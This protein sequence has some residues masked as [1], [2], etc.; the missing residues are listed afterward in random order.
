M[1]PTEWRVGLRAGA[2][3]CAST[4]KAARRESPRRRTSAP[5]LT[6]KC[7]ACCIVITRRELLRLD[8]T[9]GVPGRHYRH[10]LVPAVDTDGNMVTAVTYSAIGKDTD[11]TPSFRYISLL[12]EGARVHGLP[13]TWV[14][15]L[16]SVKHA[17]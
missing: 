4:W 5:I 17:E 2:T 16:D 3:G 6:A 8:S 1:R 11:G 7:G 12:R 9:E 10:V 14:Q 13:E 15:Y